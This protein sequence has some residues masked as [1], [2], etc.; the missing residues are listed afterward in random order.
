MSPALLNSSVFFDPSDLNDIDAILHYDD[1]PIHS[2]HVCM[3]CGR[4]ESPDH[5]LVPCS[6]CKAVFYCDVVCANENWSKSSR[7][8]CRHKNVC[9]MIQRSQKKRPALQAIAKQFLWTR[10]THDGSITYDRYRDSK[11]VFGCGSKYGWWTEAP[12]SCEDQVDYMYGMQLLEDERLDERE[13]WKLPDEEIPWLDF[14]SNDI[15]PP[16]TPPNFDHSWTSYYK[17]RSLSMHSPAALLLHWPLSVYRLLHQLHC[18]PSEVPLQRRRLVV[19]LLGVE[20]ELDV[21]PL[22]GELALL[23]PNTDIELVLFGPGVFRLLM[24]AEQDEDCLASQPYVHTYTAPDASGGSTL[25]ISLSDSGPIW[26]DHEIHTPCNRPDAMIALNANLA[27]YDQWELALLASRAY[28]IPF[29]VTESQETYDMDGVFIPYLNLAASIQSLDLRQPSP[30]D[31]H[32][33]PTQLPAIP[34]KVAATIG[35]AA[36]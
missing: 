8:A 31:S 20:K 5:K 29:A 12:C 16:P 3:N 4:I 22:F 34:P 23:I 2:T 17:W 33:Y 28:N 6:Q 25:R 27:G 30:S 24:E 7:V 26:G 14:E 19:H 18:I 21:L 13:G 10:Q 15:P 1:D 9:K 32:P 11:G 36:A 35:L